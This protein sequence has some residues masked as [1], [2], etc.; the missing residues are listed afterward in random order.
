[1]DD[2]IK[3][4]IEESIDNPDKL[5]D[6]EK[7]ISIVKSAEYSGD[8]VV[9]ATK[10]YQNKYGCDI[11]KANMFVIT[12]VSRRGIDIKYRPGTPGSK[13]CMVTILFAITTTLASYFFFI[14]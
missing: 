9:E 12:E 6:I 5:K 3:E 7:I 14:V 4:A 2:S 1:M 13:G 11:S 8:G 10:W